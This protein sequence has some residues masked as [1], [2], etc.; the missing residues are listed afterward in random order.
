RR[1]LRG[2][3]F[4]SYGVLFSIALFLMVAAVVS[5]MNAYRSVRERMRAEDA[6]R[7]LSLTDE[8]TGLYNRRGF[9]TL[10]P[11]QITAAKREGRKMLLVAADLDGLKNINDS[12]GHHEGDRSIMDA[13]QAIRQSLRKSDLIARMGG[14]EF[15]ALLTRGAERFEV[16]RIAQRISGV[17]GRDSR[18]RGYDLSMSFGFAH[19]D[20]TSETTL[21]DLL[22]IADRMMYKKKR[23]RRGS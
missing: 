11:Q 21:E 23:E 22:I 10:S 19:Y 1:E 4:R 16:D 3:L 17:L 18:G 5:T 8:L 6:L 9:M 15:V 20:P 7:H 14:D 2:L 13:A 12:Q